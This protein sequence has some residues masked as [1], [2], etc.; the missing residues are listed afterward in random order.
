MDN[1]LK[2][3]IELQKIDSRLLS[4]KELRG[5][6][7]NT[8]ADLDKELRTIKEE[9]EYTKARIEE[10]T[11]NIR[12][13]T[14]T[15]DDSTI[16]LKKLK[17]QLYIVKSNKEHDALNFEMDHLKETINSS[18]NIIIDLEEEKESIDEKN[19]NFQINIENASKTLDK[20]STEL[21]ATM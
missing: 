16:K 12:K 4:I 21:K 13:Q 9:E 6:L 3:L 1:N 15:V 5:D 19:K 17:D 8:V 2:Q 14:A 18:E 20:K 11:S 10:I 7:P